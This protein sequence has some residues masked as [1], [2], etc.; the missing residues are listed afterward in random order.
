M[1]TSFPEVPKTPCGDRGHEPAGQD[2]L[3]LYSDLLL[4]TETLHG[5]GKFEFPKNQRDI[6]VFLSW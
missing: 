3:D 5:C 4:E 6:E 1:F 2:R